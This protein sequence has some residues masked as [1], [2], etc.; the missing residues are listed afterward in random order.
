LKLHTFSLLIVTSVLAPGTA[1]ATFNP[2]FDSLTYLVNN[3]YTGGS[4][5]H[6]LNNTQYYAAEFMSSSTDTYLWSVQIAVG[7]ANYSTEALKATLYTNTGTGASSKPNTSLGQI[8][9]AV[10]VGTTGNTTITFTPTNKK[11]FLLTPN[12]EYWIAVSDTL[13]GV[14]YVDWLTVAGNS[15]TTGAAGQYWDS[16][17]STWATATDNGHNTSGATFAMKVTTADPSDVPEPVTASL[18]GAG[19]LGMAVFARRRV[20]R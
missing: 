1:H 18:A 10:T 9:A 17:S 20:R 8:G 14:H 15:H 4:T 13:A 11:D 7:G 12:T 16:F 2:I 19:L 6:H 3:S 5:G